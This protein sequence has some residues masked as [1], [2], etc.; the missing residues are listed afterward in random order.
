[1]LEKL[2]RARTQVTLQNGKFQ[3]LLNL[4]KHTKRLLIAI[5]LGLLEQ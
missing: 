5:I 4:C 3:L 1:M 2:E